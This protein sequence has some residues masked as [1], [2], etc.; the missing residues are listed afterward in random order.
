[1]NL[2]YIF[3]IVDK[4]EWDNAKK[5]GVYSGSATDIKDGYIHFS[6]KEQIYDTL[7]K[8]YHKKENL[9]LL[10]VDTLNLNHLFWEQASNGDMYPHLYSVLDIKSVKKEFELALDQNGIHNVPNLTS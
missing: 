5:I 4:D 2:K 6:E 3:K 7:K 9:L 1:M 10:K 8:Y